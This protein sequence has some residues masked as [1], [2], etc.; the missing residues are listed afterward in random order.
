M[1]TGGSRCPLSTAHLGISFFVHFSRVLI[2]DFFGCLQASRLAHLLTLRDSLQG[3]VG[4]A[5]MYMDHMGA[6]RRSSRSSASCD[7]KGF[8]ADPFHWVE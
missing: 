2:T 4:V 1:L 5:A 8:N 3:G 7:E 6:S